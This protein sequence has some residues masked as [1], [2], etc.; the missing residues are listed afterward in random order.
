MEEAVLNYLMKKGDYASFAQIE[1]NVKENVDVFTFSRE[2]LRATLQQMVK[3]GY[4][5]K[6][7]SDSSQPVAYAAVD[8]TE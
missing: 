5:I 8:L 7:A 6:D 3:D 1:K 4:I 2:D